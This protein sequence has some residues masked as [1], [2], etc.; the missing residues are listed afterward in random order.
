MLFR[1]FAQ[2][3]EQ[4]DF[5]V[6]HGLDRAELV[7]LFGWDEARFQESMAGSAIARIGYERW[8]RNLAVG[9]GNAPGDA[10]VVAALRSRSDHPSE[11]VRE[12]VQWALARHAG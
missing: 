1:S 9:L 12:H 7:D 4:P 6:R 5:K 3:T 11:L 2:I 8:L 10:N